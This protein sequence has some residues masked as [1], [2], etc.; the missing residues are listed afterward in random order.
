MS[1]EDDA[2]ER[3]RLYHLMHRGYALSRLAEL[4]Q[5]ADPVV[6][7]KARRLLREVTAELSRD[8]QD[9]SRWVTAPPGGR[10]N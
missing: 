3:A 10:P 6:R 5:C 1:G 7:R 8:G 9:V 2:Y 4:A